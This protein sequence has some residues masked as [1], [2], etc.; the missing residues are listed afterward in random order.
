MPE[1][2][3]GTSR[4][5]KPMHYSVGAII[6]N[7]YRDILL[8]DRLKPPLGWAGPAGHVDEYEGTEAAIRR[9]VLEETGLTVVKAKLILVKE[10][11]G[12]TCSRGVDCHYWHLYDCTVTGEL[13]PKL[14]E[15]KAARWVPWVELRSGLALEPIWAEWFD[16][17]G[18]MAGRPPLEPIDLR[19]GER[20]LRCG[21]CSTPLQ[22]G[23]CPNCKFAPSIQDTYIGTS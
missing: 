23:R 6:R 8:I 22:D 14:D 10:V 18:I 4:T 11:D 20:V 17:T 3:V 2:K 7:A 15:V 12:N 5:G 9:E 19:L 13:L 16:R 1:P 21:D